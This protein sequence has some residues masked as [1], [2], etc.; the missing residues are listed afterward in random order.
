MHLTMSGLGVARARASLVVGL[1]LATCVQAQPMPNAA[2]AA[3]AVATAGTTPASWRWQ[4]LPD[5]TA[6]DGSGI[7]L[8]RAACAAATY[9]ASAASKQGG[10][11]VRI[12]ARAA[13][14][15]GKT[16]L[17]KSYRQGAGMPIRS[18][19]SSVAADGTFHDELSTLNYA[20]GRYAIV[21]GEQG[22]Q[23]V[24]AAVHFELTAA[25]RSAPRTGIGTTTGLL[26][27]PQIPVRLASA[28]QVP[29]I[30]CVLPGAGGLGPRCELLDQLLNEL[31]N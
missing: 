13:A 4:N 19:L 11:V 6:S 2:A 22:G 25:E 9:C 21:Y 1:M 26:P 14:A 24:V 31:H 10:L 20:P 5:V 18:H 12:E 17:V 29:P 30:P 28:S 7:G 27:N 8:R 15:A 23:G 3:I 16:L